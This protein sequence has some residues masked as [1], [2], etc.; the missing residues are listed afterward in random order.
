MHGTST[1]ISPSVAHSF[2]TADVFAEL[3]VEADG[4]AMQD[5][6]AQQ[7]AK[8][9]KI[10]QRLVE[11]R[12]PEESTEEEDD[13][14]EMPFACYICRKCAPFLHTLCFCVGSL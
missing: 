12:D 14:E 11:G 2:R 8:R 5:W 7:K 3:F 13:E 9:E 6:Q 4:A 1:H 10:Q